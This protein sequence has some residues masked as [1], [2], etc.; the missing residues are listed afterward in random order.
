MSGVEKRYQAIFGFVDYDTEPPTYVTVHHLGG[1]EG[2]DSL[3]EV[4]AAL[5]AM[6]AAGADYP[7]ID[8]IEDTWADVK[9]PVSENVLLPCPLDALESEVTSA[10][11]AKL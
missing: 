2:W 7:E 8:E 4:R 5:Q 9:A 1:H 3:S 11:T 10:R 6:P